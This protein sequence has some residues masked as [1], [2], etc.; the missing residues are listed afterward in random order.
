MK[1]SLPWV[2]TALMAAGALLIGLNLRERDRYE[3]GSLDPV[4]GR[5]DAAHDLELLVPK[6]LT[7]GEG[8]AHPVEVVEQRRR[9]TLLD[10]DGWY[11][12]FWSGAETYHYKELVHLAADFNNPTAALPSGRW[13]IRLKAAGPCGTSP[14]D[15]LRVYEL[16]VHAL[17]SR[18]EESARMLIYAY[19]VEHRPPELNFDW[20]RVQ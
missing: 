20:V 4:D 8:C 5:E 14:F 12:L 17:E 19:D 3:L 2:L 10:R 11:R 18:P 9:L 7:H 16:R 13:E 15:G 6:A 1:A